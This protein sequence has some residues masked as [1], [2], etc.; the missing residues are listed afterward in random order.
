MNSQL[1]KLIIKPGNINGQYPSSGTTVSVHYTGMFENGS[2]F[3]SSV[4]RGT[5]F[6]FILNGNQV[7]PGWDIAVASMKKG[8]KSL[9]FIPS[10]LAYGQRGAGASIPPNTNLWFEIELL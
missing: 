8:E 6:N 5:P 9:F 3:D 10:N 4:S 2:I 7:I 1:P